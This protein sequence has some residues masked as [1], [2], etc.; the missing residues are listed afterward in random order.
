MLHKVIFILHQVLFDVGKKIL[1][2]RP[3][4]FDVA[5]TEFGCW[6]YLFFFNVALNEFAFGDYVI[7][8]LQPVNF[9]VAIT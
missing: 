9:D 1:L 4:K 5:S 8:M 6:Y 2:L 7:F 3:M